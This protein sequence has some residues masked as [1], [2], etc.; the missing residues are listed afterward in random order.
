MRRMMRRMWTTRA[1]TAAGAL[2]PLLLGG[3][4]MA[5]GPAAQASFTINFDQDGLGNPIVHGQRIDDEYRLPGS[6]IVGNPGLGVD[7]G[8]TNTGGGP[9]YAV[10][11]D[12]SLS[13][14]SDPDLENP[15]F[16]QSTGAEHTDPELRNPGNI[17]IV[18][19]N[20]NGCGDG[21]CDD[22]DDEAGGG[23]IK[24]T[25]SEAVTLF[26]LDVFDI[27]GSQSEMAFIVNG[28]TTIETVGDIGGDNHAKRIVLGGAQGVMNVT[29]L[30]V[31]FTSSGA[32]SNIKGEVPTEVPEPATGALLLLGL[33]GAGFAR[34]RL[35]A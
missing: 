13:N 26:S 17:L 10:A 20:D 18:Q 34:R 22:P 30:E 33:A 19:E 9:N 24:F 15:F 25:F 4:L 23:M 6:H 32:L 5:A 11:F 21:V 8:A 31:E 2:V 16:D 29:M 1:T 3:A 28:T 35:H 14:T 12:S 27:D 7:I